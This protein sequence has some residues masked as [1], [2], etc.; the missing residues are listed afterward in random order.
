VS[1]IVRY[2]PFGG[3]T[4]KGEYTYEDVRRD[5][6]E[7][8]HLPRETERNA[9][10][11]SADAR[12]A[13]N[14][15]LMAKYTRRNVSSPATNN[16]PEKADEGK[17]TLSWMPLLELNT[18]VG[19]D[20]VKGRSDD[21]HILDATGTGVPSA[22][23]RDIKRQRLIAHLSYL[24]LKD[25]SLTLSYAYIDSRVEQDL[26]YH[27]TTGVPLTDRRIPYREYAN[28]YAVDLSYMPKNNLMLNGGI[29]HT[30][31]R[32]NFYPTDLLGQS[33]I[34]ALS[35]TEVRETVFSVMGK[36]TVRKTFNIGLQ[37]RYARFDDVLDRPN[38][39]L[40]DGKAHTL[41]LS[42]RKEW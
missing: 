27:D 20:I 39:D 34:N 30:D 13:K 28:N 26:V 31:S 12:V 4:L 15:K 25:L 32:G 24:L 29:S 19:Y 33:G 7:E 5:D 1:G 14:V 9:A 17:F 22:E 11:L 16:E 3:L 21:L 40:N 18:S 41:L 36:Y 42:L 6:Q 10:S 23:N 8:W 2:R 37:Y 35:K 38:D